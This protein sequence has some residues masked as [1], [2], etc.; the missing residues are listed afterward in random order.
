[1]HGEGRV[2]MIVGTDFVTA[3]KTVLAFLN[4]GKLNVVAL[5]AAPGVF[6]E[7]LGE[8]SNHPKAIGVRRVDVEG[9]GIELP[10]TGIL[11]PSGMQ[12]AELDTLR[13]RLVSLSKAIRLLPRDAISLF[14]AEQFRTLGKEHKKTVIEGETIYANLHIFDVR[15]RTKQGDEVVVQ[16]FENLPVVSDE[17]EIIGVGPET[18]RVWSKVILN[19]EK[20]IALGEKPRE[21]KGALR[22]KEVLEIKDAI[23]IRALSQSEIWKVPSAFSSPLTGQTNSSPLQ[24]RQNRFTYWQEGVQFRLDDEHMRRSL[25]DMQRDEFVRQEQ[26]SIA[27][28][29]MRIP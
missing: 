7:F 17:C 9:V 15:V 5:K 21:I 1:M 2:T 6:E 26:F 22:G 27:Q 19:S 3:Y 20:I 16:T 28:Q 24:Q 8:A 11:D 14:R 18:V 29:A 12:Q 13:E 25:A 23:I 4:S 10:Q